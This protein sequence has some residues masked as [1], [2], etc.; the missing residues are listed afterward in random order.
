MA[1]LSHIF[2]NAMRLITASLLIAQAPAPALAHPESVSSLR[3][4]LESDGIH[5]LLILPT[6]DLSRWFPPGKFKN[7]QA[8][9]ARELNGVAKDLAVVACDEQ[10]V[11]ARHASA[12]MGMVGQIV[13]EADYPLPGGAESLQLQSAMLSNLPN[14]HQQLAMV[15]DARQGAAKIRIL[16]EQ[17]LTAQQN[18]LEVRLP[19]APAPSIDTTKAA[20]PQKSPPE[21]TWGWSRIL[22]TTLFIGLLLAPACRSAWVRSQHEDREQQGPL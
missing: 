14:D 6:R 9:V 20:M 19:D 22:A 16:A 4:T 3:L 11:A 18:L 21:S 1:G 2:G 15:E 5:L 10:V 12:R 8:D 7:Y 13:I 17:T